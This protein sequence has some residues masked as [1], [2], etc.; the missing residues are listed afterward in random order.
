MEI[1]E[2]GKPFPGGKGHAEGALLDIDDAGATLTVYFNGPTENEIRQFEQ[3]SPFE[4]RFVVLKGIIVF[5][6]K[7]GNL[8]WMDAPYSPHLGGKVEKI[9]FPKESEGLALSLILVDTK[10]GI[11]MSIR[12]LGL[13]TNFTKKLWGEIIEQKMQSFDRVEYYAKVNELLR[14][15]TTKEIVNMSS[16]YCKF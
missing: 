10:T 2:V 4:I 14:K 7:I 8:N 5:T 3:N 13:S 16:T 11:L 1:L 9:T 15:Y 12:F 6:V